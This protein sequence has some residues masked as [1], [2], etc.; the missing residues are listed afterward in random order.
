MLL[1]IN[2]K[3]HSHTHTP[4]NEYETESI[5][6]ALQHVFGAIIAFTCVACYY[7]ST[8][9]DF[10]FDDISAIKEN[11]D[12]R[13]H[14]PWRNLFFNDFWGTPMQKVSTLRFAL[15]YSNSFHLSA[16]KFH[17]TLHKLITMNSMAAVRMDFVT[18]LFCVGV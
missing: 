14:T 6:M 4:E 3:T 7:N 9:C 15:F 1:K 11:R 5:I 13:P 2:R 10:V 16:H 18:L 17:S 12:L 8:Q